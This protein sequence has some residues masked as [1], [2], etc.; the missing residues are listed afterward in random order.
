MGTARARAMRSDGKHGRMCPRGRGH[1]QLMATPR[2]TD[3][4]GESNM[5]RNGIVAG[6]MVVF[7]AGA[8]HGAMGPETEH[9]PMG[10]RSEMRERPIGPRIGKRGMKR[11]MMRAP[12]EDGPRGE[13]RG[14]EG[15]EG[16]PHQEDRPHEEGRG[17]DGPRGAEREDRG[18]RSEFG[19]EREM[20]GTHGG[21]GP[22]GG[23]IGRG[24]GGAHGMR[25]GP[26]P[27]FGPE[28]RG[29]PGPRG[30]FMSHG[31]PEMGGPPGAMRGRPGGH[32]GDGR[33]GPGPRGEGAIR[34][35]VDEHGGDEAG[36]P[37]RMERGERPDGPEACSECGRPMPRGA[38]AWRMKP[39]REDREEERGRREPR[40][41][42]PEPRGGSEG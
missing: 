10:D 30:G 28:G 12:H 15:R 34:G 31:R 32:L 33:G 11:P 29:G 20:E 36:G 16:R 6:L 37:R 38:G 39:E 1:C 22:R 17:D 40:E 19:P 35:P 5:K 4:R 27:R 25:L 8:A 26:G 3:P 2:A 24:M 7:M 14:E 41:E 13:R 9:P 42:R 23:P 21:P 18:P